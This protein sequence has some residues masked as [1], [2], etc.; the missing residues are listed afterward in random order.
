MLDVGAGSGS[1]I[2]A[3][4]VGRI[5]TGIGTGIGTF[6]GISPDV[7]AGIRS[8]TSPD[9]GTFGSSNLSRR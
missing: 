5:G 8:S 9:V 2:S 4:L 3:E 6:A 7:D 1:S